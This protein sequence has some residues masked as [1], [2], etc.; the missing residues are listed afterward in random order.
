MTAAERSADR[1]HPER[2]VVP[3]RPARRMNTRRRGQNAQGMIEF[4]L[5]LPVILFVVFFTIDGARLVYTY[6]SL[7][8]I[9]RDG[10]RTASLSTSTSSDCLILDRVVAA[11]QGFPI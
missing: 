10:A 1:P 4:A 11:G 8:S 3:A 6:N 9:A 7:D 5:V 2:V